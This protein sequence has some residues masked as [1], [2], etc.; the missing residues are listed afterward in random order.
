MDNQQSSTSIKAYEKHLLPSEEAKQELADAIHYFTEKL[1]ISGY[2][3]T[4][5]SN[6]ISVRSKTIGTESVDRFLDQ[7]A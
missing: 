3:P 1:Q 7:Y 6:S 4:I 5:I 2:I